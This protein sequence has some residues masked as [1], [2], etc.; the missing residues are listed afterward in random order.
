MEICVKPEIAQND[1]DLSCIKLDITV[2]KCFTKVQHF[3]IT[4]HPSVRDYCWHCCCR[5]WH[6]GQ[7]LTSKLSAYGA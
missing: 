1:T 3:A 7:K 6:C 2:S 5:Q 4:S